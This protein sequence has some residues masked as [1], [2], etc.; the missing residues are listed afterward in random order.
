[1]RFAF[2]VDDVLTGVL[3]ALLDGVLERSG[4]VDFKLFTDS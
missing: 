4:F 2:F 1:M 3:M